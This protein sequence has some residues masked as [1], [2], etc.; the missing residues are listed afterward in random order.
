M[1]YSFHTDNHS[2]FGHTLPGSARIRIYHHP[3]KK[4]IVAFDPD[5]NSLRSD[6]PTG[7]WV[8][9]QGLNEKQLKMLLPQVLTAAT[10]RLLSIRLAN[11]RSFNKNPRLFDFK[12]LQR[13]HLE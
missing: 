10:D 4:F 13:F 11:K 12:H 5:V 3:S 6:K 1:S 8:D 7:H 2:F 9:N